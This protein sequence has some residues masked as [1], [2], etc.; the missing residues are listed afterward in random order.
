MSF[1]LDTGRTHQIRVHCA[2]INHP[3]LGDPLYG[4][5]KNLP[6]RLEGQALHAVRLGL[7]HPI[8]GKEM[9][10]ESELPLDFQNLLSVLKV[11]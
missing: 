8:K 5:C 9:I 11:K 2:H 7:I 10:F 6:C 4:R 3:I 1:K